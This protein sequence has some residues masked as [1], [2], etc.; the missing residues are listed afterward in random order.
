LTRAGEPS[1][2]GDNGLAA[3][4]ASPSGDTVVATGSLRIDPGNTELEGEEPENF[5]ESVPVIEKVSRGQIAKLVNPK[6]DDLE[7]RL[8]AL[9][10]GVTSA[11]R[12]AN[13]ARAESFI[14]KVKGKVT[15]FDAIINNPKWQ[16]WIKNRLPGSRITYVQSLADANAAGDLEAVS[17]IFAAFEAAN[18]SAAPTDTSGFSG[19]DTA[20]AGSTREPAPS[21]NKVILKMSDRRKLSEDFLKGRI[22]RSVYE[23]EKEKFTIADREGR[24]DYSN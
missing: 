16:A 10:S 3:P 20:N 17:E 7:R 2:A 1:K 11:T 15:N 8:I 23:A 6:L 21:G 9:E 4:A 5:G 18:P 13:T 24:V 22:E 14:D 12:T 19:V